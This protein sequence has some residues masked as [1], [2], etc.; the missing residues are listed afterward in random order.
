MA[1]FTN[2]PGI[3][4][5]NNLKSLNLGHIFNQNVDHLKLPKGLTSLRFPDHNFRHSLAHLDLPD[6]ITKLNLSEDQSI[7][8]VRLPRSL[9]KMILYNSMYLTHPNNKVS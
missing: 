8:N 1:S 6:S 2:L 3:S 5:I 4:L 9:K 7:L